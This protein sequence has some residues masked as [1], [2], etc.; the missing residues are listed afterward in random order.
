VAAATSDPTK[1]DSDDARWAA[2]QLAEAAATVHGLLADL[3]AA[4]E[5]CGRPK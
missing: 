2:R 3:T 4:A 1:G 5:G